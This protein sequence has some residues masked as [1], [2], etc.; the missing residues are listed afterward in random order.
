MSRPLEMLEEA[1]NSNPANFGKLLQAEMMQRIMEAVEEKKAD[2]VGKSFNFE[3]KKDDSNDDEDN[4]SDNDDSS[5][6]EK[7]NKQKSNKE[8]DADQ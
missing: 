5:N 4:N 6:D 1:R 7:S 8:T 3:K 2:E